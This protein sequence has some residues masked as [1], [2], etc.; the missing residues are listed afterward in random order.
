MNKQPQGVD[1]RLNKTVDQRL[2][3]AVDQRLVE[4]IDQRLIE[5]VDL[6]LEKDWWS[7]VAAQSPYPLKAFCHSSNSLCLEIH[8]SRKYKNLKKSITRN[9]LVWEHSS[10]HQKV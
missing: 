7:T 2:N 9:L 3:E 8:F 5:A 4:A 6:R 1:K 10:F